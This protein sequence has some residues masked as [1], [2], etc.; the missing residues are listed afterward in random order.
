MQCLSTFDSLVIL[1]FCYFWGR[2]QSPGGKH[3][4]KLWVESVVEQEVTCCQAQQPSSGK[5][6]PA[7]LQTPSPGVLT[8]LLG[9]KQPM[10][11][12]SMSWSPQ[13]LSISQNPPH[14]PPTP[15]D[16]QEWAVQNCLYCVLPSPGFHTEH[17]TRKQRFREVKW[18]FQGHQ[19]WNCL[20]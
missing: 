12:W 13:V 8:G 17:R 19:N 5:V 10:F 7:S 1:L 3:T 14:L 6:Q 9:L 16:M 20:G 4:G 2:S 15:A 11:R 18:L